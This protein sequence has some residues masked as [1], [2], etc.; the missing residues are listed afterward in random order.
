MCASTYPEKLINNLRAEIEALKEIASNTAKR[1]K[2][3]RDQVVELKQRL[4]F[5]IR[6][7]E[8]LRYPRDAIDI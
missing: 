7:N 4:D 1:E 5:H 3:W 2:F 8:R 6:Q